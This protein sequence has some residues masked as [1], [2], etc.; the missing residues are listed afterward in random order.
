MLLAKLATTCFVLRGWGTEW[1]HEVVSLTPDLGPTSSVVRRQVRTLR[2]AARVLG[3]WENVI[4]PLPRHQGWFA[5][6]TITGYGSVVWLRGSLQLYVA[7][8]R[9]RLSPLL[10]VL[11]CPLLLH[12]A[13]YFMTPCAVFLIRNLNTR[14]GNYS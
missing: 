14:H 4:L 1:A 5:I 11:P 10:P 3:G 6:I 9:A 2:G 7:V 12:P 8:L 13:I